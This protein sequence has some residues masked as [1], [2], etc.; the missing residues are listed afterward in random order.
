VTS[1]LP[2]GPMEA[3]FIPE[4]NELGRCGH[5]VFLV[6][7]HPRGQIVH[8]DAKRMPART[9]GEPLVSVRV[10]AGAAV[11]ALH[12]P[13]AAVTAFIGLFKSRNVRILAKN[14]LV[15]P[16]GLWLARNVR[17]WRVDHI[18]AHWASTSATMAWIASE[19]TGVPWSFTAHRWD[20]SE[21]NLLPTKARSAAFIRCISG[22]GVTEI[23]RYVGVFDSK[24]CII[25]MGVPLPLRVSARRQREE[26]RIIT[27]AN[28]RAV[29][30]HRYLIEAARLC[31]DRGVRISVELAGDGPLRGYLEA[32]VM[33]AGLADTVRFLGVLAHEELLEGMLQGRWDVAVLPSI[34]V[35]ESE[36]E[37]IPVFL[38]EAMATGL[39]VIAT[40][41]GGIS[42]L[43][44][45]GAGL[46]VRERDPEGLEAA[47]RTLTADSAL[48]ETLA[49]RGRERVMS[50]FDIRAVAGQ[51]IARMERAQRSDGSVESAPPAN[52]M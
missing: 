25:H 16:K 12:S 18:H 43:L 33:A 13:V 41:T 42:E 24:V 10:L 28:L 20:I 35:S 23:S 5:E 29:K 9:V 40:Q 45:N 31:R 38:I 6:P 39:P 37:G 3:F 1:M 46:L 30:G 36:Q 8:S 52:G 15:F 2:F 47:L 44:E 49:V 51:L 19:M 4:L 50:Q 21:N 11:E 17:R 32:Q 7:M 27:A 26:F 22:R 48:Y 14:L 34:I